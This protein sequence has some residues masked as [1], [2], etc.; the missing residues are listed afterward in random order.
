MSRLAMQIQAFAASQDGAAILVSDIDRA[1][2][3]LVTNG[4]AVAELQVDERDGQKFQAFFV[5]APDSLC[6]Y[7][8]Q[9]IS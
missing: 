4:V 9:P 8:H 2:S 3:E 6:Y 7:F 5:V 1:K